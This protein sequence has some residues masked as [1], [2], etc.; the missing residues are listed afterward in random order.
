LRLLATAQPER[1]H[2]AL[3]A[4]GLKWL[5]ERAQLPASLVAV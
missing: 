3:P 4:L 2:A 1:L 5:A